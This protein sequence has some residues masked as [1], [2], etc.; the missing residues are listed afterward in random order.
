M[1][2]QKEQASKTQKLTGIFENELNRKQNLIIA[3][4]NSINSF[5][6]LSRT[7]LTISP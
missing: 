2:P 5:W 1:K 4:K 7:R 3:T 6:L